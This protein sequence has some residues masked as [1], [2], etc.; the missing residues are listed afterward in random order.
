VAGAHTELHTASA[1]GVDLY[2]WLTFGDQLL[3]EQHSHSPGPERSI[4]A[5]HSLLSSLPSEDDWM[6]E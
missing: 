3:I 6:A 2:A 5:I 4:E 1:A